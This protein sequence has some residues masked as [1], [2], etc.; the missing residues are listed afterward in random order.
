MRTQT[1]YCSFDAPC[2]RPGLS[3]RGAGRLDRRCDRSR[4]AQDV[5]QRV[6]D[7][8]VLADRGGG[9]ENEWSQLR[10]ATRR[11]G[12]RLPARLA[13]RLRAAS[14][15]KC[16]TAYRSAC[17]T[18]SRLPTSADPVAIGSHAEPRQT[19]AG[20]TQVRAGPDKRSAP[21]K[22][23]NDVGS[24]PSAQDVVAD[25]AHDRGSAYSGT[26]TETEPDP[27]VGPVAPVGPVTPAG[28][29]GARV[30]GPVG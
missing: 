14:H 27:G 11:L 21:V 17:G 23:G 22:P 28:R 2:A 1:P 15:N 4:Q 3:Q 16:G 8:A 18:G 19:G 20:R 25:R 30:R 13:L 29:S 10:G 12:P 6:L 26:T 7:R 5:R 9:H 24:R